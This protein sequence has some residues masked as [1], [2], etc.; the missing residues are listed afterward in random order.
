MSSI[1]FQ[2]TWQRAFGTYPLHGAELDHALSSA[3]AVGYR[4]VDTAQM[5]NNEADVGKVLRGCGIDRDEL[6]ITTKVHPDHFNPKQF[7]PSVEQS[8]RDL[9]LEQVDVL[10][11]HWP[12]LGGD[13]EPGLHWLAEAQQRGLTRHIG[14]SNYNSAML[15]Q[16]VSLLDTPLVANQ[17]EF[18]PLLDQ[19]RLLQAANET[20]IPL[21][22]Y[23]SVARGEALKQPL[24]QTL[25][26]AYGRSPAQ[27]VLRWILQKGVPINTMSTKPDNIRAN[28][29]VMDFTLS[30]GDMAQ[31]DKLATSGYRIVTKDISRWAPEW[32]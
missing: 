25:A 3:F 13:I 1:Y 21:T 31:M 19:S 14:V 17:V 2:N 5:Y 11:L 26:Q 20:G 12:A 24:V 15:R 32:D 28:F 7:I 30:S 27:I 8:L 6:C 9:Q 18:H 22:S 29:D 10:L 23:C 16:A 4:A